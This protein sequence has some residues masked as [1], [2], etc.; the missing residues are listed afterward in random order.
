MQLKPFHSICVVGQNNQAASLYGKVSAY[1]SKGYA[2]IYAVETTVTDT[3][4]RMNDAGIRSGKYIENNALT[5]L[6]R[7][8]VYSHDTTK[9]EGRRV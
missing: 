1:L 2:V 6:D 4:Q 5:I 3:M 9:L 8:S 7:N